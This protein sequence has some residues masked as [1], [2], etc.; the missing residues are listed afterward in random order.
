MR[1][2]RQSSKRVANWV[3]ACSAW[4]VPWGW[5]MLRQVV[6]MCAS[7]SDDVLGDTEANATSDVTHA[8]RRLTDGQ[9]PPPPG[10]ELSV[11]EDSR[12]GAVTSGCRACGVCLYSIA[13]ACRV[14]LPAPYVSRLSLGSVGPKWPPQRPSDSAGAAAARFGGRPISSRVPGAVAT[15]SPAAADAALAGSAWPW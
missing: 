1:R 10:E 8:H 11:D 5:V 9:P 12:T 7:K 2:W 13:S 4:A 3:S 15:R 6:F 14:V